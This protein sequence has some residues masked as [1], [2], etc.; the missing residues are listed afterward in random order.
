MTDASTF[1]IF[2]SLSPFSSTFIQQYCEGGW[3]EASPFPA[4]PLF[5]H[6]HPFFSSP[7]LFLFSSRLAYLLQVTPAD[8]ARRLAAAH[9]ERRIRR[10][11]SVSSL[12]V[13]RWGST[14]SWSPRKRSW[15]GQSFPRL[16]PSPADSSSASSLTRPFAAT[17]S[18][19]VSLTVAQ[20]R[21]RGRETR[22][23][24]RVLETLQLRLPSASRHSIG[25]LWGVKEWNW[26]AFPF[27]A[28]FC[29]LS[30]LFFLIFHPLS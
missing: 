19:I 11:P 21:Q 29:L 13:P 2:S 10:P 6:L 20:V 14:A 25:P 18:V 27:P 1:L 23:S 4:L 7:L 24:T 12:A 17:H 16:P 9:S 28:S 8:H 3:R 15:P 26:A 22:A 5:L 30:P